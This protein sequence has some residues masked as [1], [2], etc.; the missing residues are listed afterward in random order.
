[1]KRSVTLGSVLALSLA[2]IIA[3]AAVI[4][5]LAHNKPSGPTLYSSG[6]HVTLLLPPAPTKPPPAPAG[7]P[8]HPTALRIF[9]DDVDRRSDFGAADLML[10]SIWVSA[11]NRFVP[12][13]YISDNPKQ[14]D[15]IKAAWVGTSIWH[16]TAAPNV[17]TVTDKELEVWK[18]GDTVTVNLT[19]SE[20]IK[21]GTLFP[22]LKP[23]NFTLPPIAIEFR[24]IDDA[25]K[26][27]EETTTFAPSPPYSGYKLT[28]THIDKPAWVRVWIPAWLGAQQIEFAGVLNVQETKT[29]TAP[30]AP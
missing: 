12:V 2:V 11:V 7:T 8:T 15:L 25:Y 30:S 26:E 3:V 29:Y 18:H 20:D 6:G 22:N 23:L 1:M 24:G 28:E 4:P 17:F 10:V 13:A 27:P 19:V 14:S 5:A 9:A 16:P 21:F